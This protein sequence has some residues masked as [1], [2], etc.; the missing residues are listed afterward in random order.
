MIGDKKQTRDCVFITIRDSAKLFEGVKLPQGS[1]NYTLWYKK[2]DPNVWGVTVKKFDRTSPVF[3]S[4]HIWKI[5]WKN[6]DGKL[7][8]CTQLD[9]FSM[10]IITD[11]QYL[12]FEN[13]I[14]AHLEKK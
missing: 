4:Q 6:T 11:T 1:S 14:K 8:P 10:E 9:G 7:V 3:P 2:S 12:G 13:I 5:T